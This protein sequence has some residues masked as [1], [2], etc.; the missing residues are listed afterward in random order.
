MSVTAKNKHIDDLHFEHQLWKSQANFYSD[1]LSI[2]QKRL[3]EVASKNTKEEV[4]KQIE[5][6][7]NQFIIQKQELARIS[8]DVEAHE[9]ELAAFAKAHPV[10]IDHKVFG[11]HA[12]MHDRV[13]TFNKL[14]SEL[15]K[16]FT[17][18]LT[19]WM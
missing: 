17:Q 16:E 9:H 19:V 18:F 5:H 14:Y 12:Q 8:H 7:Q 11:D 6:F 1:E 2:Y 4:R 10:A 13:D 15:K 3:Q